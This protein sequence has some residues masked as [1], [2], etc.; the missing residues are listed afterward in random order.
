VLF[1]YYDTLR[2]AAQ[3]RQMRRSVGKDC[4]DNK[5]TERS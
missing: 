2:V 5:E 4:F 3:I 1:R